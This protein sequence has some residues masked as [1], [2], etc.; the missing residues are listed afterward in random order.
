MRAVQF[1]VR[2]AGRSRAATGRWVFETIIRAHVHF[3]GKFLCDELGRRIRRRN[4]LKA[5]TVR[6]VVGREVKSGR[7]IAGNNS[8]VLAV[9]VAIAYRDYREGVSRGVAVNDIYDNSGRPTSETTT[10]SS[11]Q[12]G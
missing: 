11:V 3:R 5:S 12:C 1:I 6:L 4:R 2:G 9:A 7:C 8:N 10:I